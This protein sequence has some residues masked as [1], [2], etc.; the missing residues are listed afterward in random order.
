MTK[1]QEPSDRKE[2]KPAR[3]PYQPPRIESEPVFEAVGTCNLADTSC[4]LP[5]TS[6]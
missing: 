6:G 4:P 5:R 3:Q 2:T 1:Q